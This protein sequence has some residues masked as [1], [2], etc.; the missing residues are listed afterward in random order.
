M[1]IDQFVLVIEMSKC[2]RTFRQKHLDNESIDEQ[3]AIA[4]DRVD[5]N[6]VYVKTYSEANQIDIR[7]QYDIKRPISQRSR[8]A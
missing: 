7:A 2:F 1:F 5:I 4:K 8:N 6:K 3:I